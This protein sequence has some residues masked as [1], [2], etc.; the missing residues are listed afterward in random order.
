MRTGHR[1]LRDGETPAA[2]EVLDRGHPR[3]RPPRGSSA[4]VADSSAPPPDLPPCPHAPIAALPDGR[5]AHGFGS[6]RCER[7]SSPNAAF[8][9]QHASERVIWPIL[10]SPSA[11]SCGSV[12]TRWDGETGQL[13]VSSSAAPPIWGGIAHEHHHG[14]RRHPTGRRFCRAHHE[15]DARRRRCQ[16]EGQRDARPLRA[17]AEPGTSAAAE[18]NHGCDEQYDGR[19]PTPRPSSSTLIVLSA[20][21]IPFGD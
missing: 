10:V 2:A 12:V 18:L 15:T 6:V 4:T 13:G 5:H 21:S 17:G 7:V 9:E 20:T 8:L 16:P 19:G 1:G 14:I 3:R 11:R